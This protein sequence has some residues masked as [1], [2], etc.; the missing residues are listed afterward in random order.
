MSATL[1]SMLGQQVAVLQP[2]APHKYTCTRENHLSD[3]LHVVALQ[4][5]F[6]PRGLW[7]GCATNLLQKTD[8]SQ[9]HRQV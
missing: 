9:W 8:T 2:Y 5:A 1:D 6:Q 3:L 4:T 7:T